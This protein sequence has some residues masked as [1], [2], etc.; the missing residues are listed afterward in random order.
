VIALRGR[1][2]HVLSV[3]IVAIVLGMVAAACSPTASSSPAPSASAA[4]S[5]AT[6]PSLTPVPGGPSNPAV[7]AS[8]EL[9]T[10]TATEFGEIWD[11]LPPSFPRLP[12]QEPA[13]TGAGPASGSFAVNMSADDAARTM[14]AALTTLGWT[15]DVTSALED[16][17]VVL[18]ATG[19]REGCVAE[20]RFTPTSGTV[21]MSV[22]Y[23]ADCP[24]S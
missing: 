18:E 19:A 23:G 12:G 20:V 1:A 16:G 4:P 2:A 3:A 10:T 22:L 15:A 6:V 24:F 5:T 8:I 9:P 14:A 21:V 11:A 7:S 17:T 13:E